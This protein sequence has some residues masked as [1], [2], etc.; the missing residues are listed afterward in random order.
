MK[1]F[2]SFCRPLVLFA[3]SGFDRLRFCGESRLLNHAGGVNSYLYQQHLLRK[4][5]PAHCAKLTAILRD[6]STAQA[7]REGVP[8]ATAGQAVRPGV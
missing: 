4:D 2:L 7:V 6:D 1:S 8:A 5:F 3:L